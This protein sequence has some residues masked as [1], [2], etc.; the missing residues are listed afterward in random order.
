[1]KRLVSAVLILLTVA[2]LTFGVF[3]EGS[4]GASASA[5]SP[6]RE[7]FR[8]DFEDGRTGSA[9]RQ[10]L[11]RVIADPANAANSCLEILSNNQKD[12]YYHIDAKETESYLLDPD[13][14][15]GK[16][17]YFDSDLLIFSLKHSR[18]EA[19]VHPVNGQIKST[20]VDG[21]TAQK[22]LYTIDSSGNLK[23]AGGTV[24][25]TLRAGEWTAIDIGLDL[26]T[27]S[28][29]YY[30]DRVFKASETFFFSQKISYFNL[31]H[32]VREAGQVL[33]ADDLA[34]TYGALTDAFYEVPVEFITASG[35]TTL[36][37]TTPTFRL[38]DTAP[39]WYGTVGGKRVMLS[40]GSELE[41]VKGL[42][43]TANE[44]LPVLLD[45]ASIR[46][47][48]HTGLRF[49]AVYDTEWYDTL[50]IFFGSDALTV[51]MLIVPTDYLA[52][53][54]AFTHAALSEKY[55]VIADLTVPAWYSYEGGYGCYGTLSELKDE[56]YARKFSARAYLKIIDG[57]GNATYLYSAYDPEKNA[58]SAYEVA[59]AAFADT[60]AGYTEAQRSAIRG[61]L[62]GT[63]ALTVSGEGVSVAEG[64]LG[65]TSPYALVSA[66]ASTAVF[67]IAPGA[68]LKTVTVN[69]APLYTFTV[70]DGTVTVVLN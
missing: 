23:T 33:L 57:E 5:A 7:I 67:S 39:Y 10:E 34:V 12:L 27:G 18:T 35:R 49:G 20:T 47:D 4:G 16:N 30:V 28:I 63:L 19:T 38:P 58:R 41:T 66:D 62:D 54:T 56:N 51:G 8:R 61:Y 2:T 31:S 25:G 32:G 24:I 36:R 1:M 40:A 68:T 22:S 69:G 3:A 17:F 43:F 6:M 53:G 64:P 50:R 11:C 70:G 42:S 37:Y 46:A 15:S 21:S 13:A 14:A 48:Y 52:D 59:S 9:Y 29:S 65:Y 45:G 44:T 26:K 55:S 60:A